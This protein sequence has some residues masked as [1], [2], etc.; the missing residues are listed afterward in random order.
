MLINR[1]FLITYIFFEYAEGQEAYGS[2]I[3]TTNRGSV[4]PLKFTMLDVPDGKFHDKRGKLSPFE[5]D[6]SGNCIISA[7]QT[8]IGSPCI[9]D[10]GLSTATFSFDDVSQYQYIEET[11][12][13]YEYT[14]YFADDCQFPT[15]KSGDI[16]IP[17]LIPLHRYLKGETSVDLKFKIYDPP[18]TKEINLYENS[19]VICSWRKGVSMDENICPHL[20]TDSTTLI[21]DVTIKL[22]KGVS[23]FVT[24]K[25]GT[26]DSSVALTLDWNN[27]GT[28]PE[29]DECQGHFLTPTSTTDPAIPSQNINMLSSVN[30]LSLGVRMSPPMR[31][32]TFA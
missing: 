23:S 2:R 9:F 21:S 22:N 14:V 18:T 26:A 27:A 24:Y 3:I 30:L 11:D 8:R 13:I 16:L 1:L 17:P 31:V 6:S 28:P 5:I 29:V 4:G 25:W 10:K 15:P 20:T 19:S 32:Y 12:G 7:T